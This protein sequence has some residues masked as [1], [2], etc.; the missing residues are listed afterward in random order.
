MRP[1][2]YS[3]EPQARA[4]GANCKNYFACFAQ[5]AEHMPVQAI[6]LPHF[7]QF[8]SHF[9]SPPHFGHFAV[10]PCALSPPHLPQQAFP[11]LHSALLS[12]QHLP[13]LPQHAALSF[14]GTSRRSSSAHA[15]ERPSIST[16]QRT[17][18]T[19]SRCRA[20]QRVDGP[21]STPMDF[22]TASSSSSGRAIPGTS[23]PRRTPGAS[24]ASTSLSCCGSSP[25]KQPQ[26]SEPRTSEEK[27]GKAGEPPRPVPTA[28]QRSC[29]RCSRA[30]STRRRSLS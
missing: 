29:R 7:P 6:G 11:S 27:S 23:R 12:L 22:A 9:I 10:Q 20:A 17:S 28:S 24:N 25:E 19:A 16:R 1:A 30:T 2:S 8:M 26:N 14:A 3:S 13:S 4:R 15:R 21:S 5:H 18:T